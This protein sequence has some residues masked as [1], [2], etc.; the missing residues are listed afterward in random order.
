MFKRR[1]DKVIEDL[2]AATCGLHSDKRQNYVLAQALHGLVRLA[3]A[4]Q[5][6]EMRMDAEKASGSLACASRKR[7]TRAILRKIGMDVKSRQRELEF[8]QQYPEGKDE[9]S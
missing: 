5:L 2:T 9:T 3:K 8:G 6:L 1:T 4:E 7:Q